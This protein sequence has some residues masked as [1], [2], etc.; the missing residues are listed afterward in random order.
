MLYIISLYNFILYIILINFIRKFLAFLVRF[1]FSE[2]YSC[3]N[4][5]SF[6]EE[7]FNVIRNILD[8][9]TSRNHHSPE[10]AK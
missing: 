5:F 7:G 4:I 10:P 2:A 1:I 6:Y 8:F 3:K 9:S